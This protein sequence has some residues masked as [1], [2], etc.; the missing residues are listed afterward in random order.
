MEGKKTAGGV[1]EKHPA[2]RSATAAPGHA[3]NRRTTGVCAARHATCSGPGVWAGGDAGLRFGAAL[4]IE[5]E[6]NRGC[7]GR[8]GGDPAR[9]Q[10]LGAPDPGGGRGCGIVRSCA[11]PVPPLRAG[12]GR[13]VLPAAGILPASGETRRC[14]DAPGHRAGRGADRVIFAMDFGGKFATRIFGPWDN[15]RRRGNGDRPRADRPWARSIMRFEREKSGQ[16]PA[17]RTG[18]LAHV[19]DAHGLRDRGVRAPE[20]LFAKDASGRRGSDCRVG[21][22]HAGEYTPAF[23]NSAG[24]G[25]DSRR[26][27]SSLAALC[28]RRVPRRSGVFPRSRAFFIT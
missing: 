22:F 15:G 1:M 5:R 9:R 23:S 26:L 12:R 21:R 6:N 28:E 27:Q 4:A 19:H 17:T 7:R 24:G 14:R 13:R 25:F 10:P 18:P 11:R 2:T 16:G 8:M 20:T 3:R